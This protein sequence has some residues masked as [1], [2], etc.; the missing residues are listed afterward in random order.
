MY[1]N[2]IFIPKKIIKIIK[3]ISNQELETKKSKLETEK[4]KSKNEEKKKKKMKKKRRKK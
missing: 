2:K 1:S 4:S 3:I